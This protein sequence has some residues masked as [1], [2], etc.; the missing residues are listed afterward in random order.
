MIRLTRLNDREIVLNAELIKTIE[1][2]PDTMITLINGDQITVREPMDEVIR[3]AIEYLR[4][5]RAF[6]PTGA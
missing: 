5:I 3:R 2:T 6:T 4:S 1:K